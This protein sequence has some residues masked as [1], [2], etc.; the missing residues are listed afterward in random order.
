LDSK[1]VKDEQKSISISLGKEYLI[2]E[3]TL[4]KIASEPMLSDKIG[5]SIN[6]ELSLEKVF[7][8]HIIK[9]IENYYSDIVSID[10]NNLPKHLKL[11]YKTDKYNYIQLEISTSTFTRETEIRNL[12][13]Q[14]NFLHRPLFDSNEINNFNKEV[15]LFLAIALA[16]YNIKSSLEILIKVISEIDFVSHKDFILLDP[17]G[18]LVLAKAKNEIELYDRLVLTI[19]EN[20]RFDLFFFFDLA[21][22]TIEPKGLQNSRIRNLTH[23]I[24]INQDEALLGTCY[25]NLGNIY[26]ND[27]SSDKAINSYFLARRLQ[28]DYLNR[29]YWWREMAGLIFSKGHYSWAEQFYKKSLELVKNKGVGKKYSRMV[30][31]NPDEQFLVTALIADCLFFQGKF[32]ESHD[33]FEK[34]IKASNSNSQEWTLKNMICMELID[35]ELDCVKLDRKQSMQLCEEAI[36][37][38]KKEKLID[39]L[40][41]SIKLDPTNGLAWFN[42]G[43]A[44]DKLGKYDEALFSFIFT[45]LLQDWDKEAQFNALTVSFTT[46]NLDMMQSLLLFFYQKHGDLVINELSDYIMEKNIPLEGK[47]ALIEAFSEIFEVVKTMHNK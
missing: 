33:Y 24:D 4:V 21:Y 41:D 7:N 42:L 45:G 19:I 15:L 1:K 26:K 10:F 12:S 8:N 27:L 44:Q 25:Y 37:L 29:D 47:K 16:K 46:Q 22:F 5:I 28:P 14:E 39:K 11:N 3:N 38:P 9:W 6:A 36:Q 40:N 23:I 35:G 30:I 17:V 20:K 2:D 43:V 18:L 31:D 32:K 34:Y 13:E